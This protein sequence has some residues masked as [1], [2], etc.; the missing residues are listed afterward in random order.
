MK[1]DG[2]RRY[3]DLSTRSDGA[4]ILNLLD[5]RTHSRASS[6]P[7]SSMAVSHSQVLVALGLFFRNLE[8]TQASD[9]WY[10]KS[11]TAIEFCWRW[12]EEQPHLSFLWTYAASFQAFDAGY[13]ELARKLR[14]PCSS[15]GSSKDAVRD[16]VK[17]WLE[18][19]S[20]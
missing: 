17:D 19:N 2:L 4:R 6:R 9:K 10:S 16:G 7:L 8:P 1:P 15:P 5:V 11:Q 12:L 13:A 20:D 14:L 3:A 18:D